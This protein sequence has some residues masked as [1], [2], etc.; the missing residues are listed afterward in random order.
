MSR[1]LARMTGEQRVVLD[2]VP[3]DVY[4]SLLGDHHTRLTYDR[5]VL[6]LMSPG[7]T[8]ERLAR[9]IGYLVA[10]LVDVWGLDLEDLGS[11]TFKE[12]AWERGFEPDA[13]FYIGDAAGVRAGGGTDARRPPAPEIVVEID[14]S[15]TSID[16]L[17]VFSQFGVPEVWR[18]DGRDAT[19]LGLEDGVYRLAEVSRALPPLTADVLSRLLERGLDSPRR[20]WLEDIRAWATAA[21]AAG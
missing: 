15:R 19:I 9:R 12:P 3:W 14:I 11:T 21:R 7:E 18:H 6:E 17:P 16:K 4:E 8:H 5:G 1:T 20:R 2:D 13:C 10:A